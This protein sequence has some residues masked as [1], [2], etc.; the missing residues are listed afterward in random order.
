[1]SDASIYV[2][3]NPAAGRGRAEQRLETLRQTHRNQ[4]VFVPTD[5]PG[6]AELL[7]YEAAKAGYRTVGA[8]GGDGTVHEVA[9]GLLRAALPETAMAIYPIGSANDYAFTLG[10]GPD[11]WLAPTPAPQPRPV[12]VGL[13]RTSSGRRRYFINGLGLGF[14]GAVTLE[15]RRVRWL[16]GVPL[17][18]VALLRALLFRFHAPRMSIRID[19]NVREVPT[20]ALTV[21]IGRREGNF[22][23]APNAKVD[24]GWFDYLQAGALPR[25]QLIRYVPGMITGNLPTDHP[26]L[27]TGLCRQVQLHTGTP[28]PVHLDGEL[29]CRPDDGVQDLDIE[30]LPGRLRV[31]WPGS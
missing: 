12:D 9:N 2:I 21:A 4:A 25:W 10:I 16:Q 24:D 14:N 23:L 5:R 26:Q 20:L 11:W 30:I 28:V 13:V 18:T 22:L 1:V 15:S 3:Y 29:F 17:Y 19:G 6:H 8:A 31:L 7:A 27:W